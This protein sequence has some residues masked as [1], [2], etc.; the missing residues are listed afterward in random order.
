MN[1]LLYFFWISLTITGCLVLSLRRATRFKFPVNLYFSITGWMLITIPLGARLFHILY[2][3]LDYYLADPIRAFQIWRGGFVYFGGL[4]F[5]LLF[6]IFY[7]LKPRARSF[8]QTA[9]FFTPVLSLGTGVG[10]IACFLQGCCYGRELNTFWAVRGLHPT[11]LYIFFWEMIL[12]GLILKIE[13]RKWK[14]GKIFL[15]WLSLSAFG[16][17]V[18][19]FYRDDFRGQMIAWLSISQVISLGIVGICCATYLYLKNVSE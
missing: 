18:V 4:T 7:F 10:R 15:F 13:N 11:Q 5:S 16:R 6:F 17:F 1:E 14:S 8:W 3:D 12:F 9:D 2:E 19:E